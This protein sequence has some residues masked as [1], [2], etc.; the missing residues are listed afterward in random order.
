M[1]L[2]K[3]FIIYNSM[4]TSV[5]KLNNSILFLYYFTQPE[6]QQVDF[7]PAQQSGDQPPAFPK[8][9]Q[10]KSEDRFLDMKPQRP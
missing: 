6:L 1:C 5:W 7:I 9:L 2:F 8:L 4:G 3:E 10:G